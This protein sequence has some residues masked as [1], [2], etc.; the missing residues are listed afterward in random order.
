MSNPHQNANCKAKRDSSTHKMEA[1]PDPTLNRV[2][3]NK[4]EYNTFAFI[5]GE[6]AQRCG[7]FQVHE[8]VANNNGIAMIGVFTSETIHKLGVAHTL[9]PRPHQTTPPDIS[10]PEDRSGSAA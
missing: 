6:L 3:K 1:P 5:G 10:E 2:T 9:P 7:D 8:N 4:T